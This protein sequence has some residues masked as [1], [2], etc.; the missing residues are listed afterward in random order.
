MN[1]I[2]KFLLLPLLLL[3]TALPL[4]AEEKSWY[5]IDGIRVTPVGDLF[6]PNLSGLV[7]PVVIYMPWKIES[8][9]SP[10]FSDAPKNAAAI[11]VKNIQKPLF[12]FA[13]ELPETPSEP[14]ITN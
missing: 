10:Y 12:P 2:L 5:E 8:R 4:Q 14:I 11:A 13:L 1:L 7:N 3:L 9:I 6:N